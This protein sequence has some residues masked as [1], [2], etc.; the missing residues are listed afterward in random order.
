MADLQ[1]TTDPGVR[2]NS[3][4]VGLEEKAKVGHWKQAET[5][6]IKQPVSV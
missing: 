2:V 4:S 5:D 1:E 6:F 3:R